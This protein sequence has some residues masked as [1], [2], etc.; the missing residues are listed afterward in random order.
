MES[1][2]LAGNQTISSKFLL[3]LDMIPFMQWWLVI[4]GLGLIFLPLSNLLFSNLSDKGY[5]F[6]KTIGIALSGYTMWFLSNIKLMKFRTISCILVVGIW[7]VFNLLI[8]IYKKY[9]TNDRQFLSCYIK[10]DNIRI[11]ITQEI[12][13][14]I[15]FLLFT[16][17][18]GFK[19]EAYGT[20]KFMDYGF[21]TTMMRSDYMPPQDFWFS[22]TKLNY[23]YVGQFLATFLTR[24]S[25]VEV[26]KGYNLMLMMIG[27]FAFML[28]FSLA[29]NLI[30]R[31][32]SV[33][34]KKPSILATLS[35]IFAGL[36]VCVAGNM[37][38]PIY[39]WI[40]PVLQRIKG[41]AK[42]PFSYW[43]PNATRYIGYNPETNDKTIHEFPAYSFILGDLH[44]HV[45]NILFVLTVLAVLLSW[46]YGQ[47]DKRKIYGFV[48]NKSKDK[49]NKNNENHE[50]GLIIK[51]KK[52]HEKNPIKN[53]NKTINID[54]YNDILKELLN[55]SIIII[56][57][58][59]GL[60][61]T[62]NFWDFP[63]YFVVS[64][65]IILF[66]N[67]ISYD[68]K[69]KSLW[70]T[71][72]QGIIIIVTSEII[73]LPFTLQFDQI[74]AMVYLSEN[75]TPFYQLMV[76]WGLPIF[77]VTVFLII[78]IFDYVDKRNTASRT[79]KSKKNNKNIST[80]FRV[81][82]L[83]RTYMESL[84]D[85]DLFVITIG[86]CAM[87][88]ILIPEIVY[89]KDI[90][91]GDYKRAN[92]MF[93]LT[94]QAFIIFGV[95]LGYIF[96]RL[97]KYGRK[98][99]QRITAT[100]SLIAFCLTLPYSVNAVKAW[101]GGGNAY[102]G[103]DAAAFMKEDFRDDYLATKWLNDNVSGTPV[104]LEANGLSYTDYQRVSVITGL[105]TVLGWYTHEQLWKSQPSKTND[106]VVSQLNTR[107]QD[108]EAIYTS[109]DKNLVKS[110]IDKYDVSYIYVGLLEEEKYENLNHDLIKSLGEVV[111][112]NPNSEE[113]EYKTYIVKIGI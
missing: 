67:L 103:I 61:H 1:I 37:H 19:P 75:H 105:P 6:S 30:I 100:I 31:F 63:I 66:S 3:G 21:M 14:F 69:I 54:N 8:V 20:E 38:Y 101:Y 77:T 73:A 113:Y 80:D 44:A 55:P 64:G 88:L 4:L 15:I 62:T 96:I 52:H 12:L 49:S 34:N 112:E 9:Y 84:S 7:I 10:K 68:F 90:Y 87:G 79:R 99:G 59:L 43:F 72:L 110:L 45:I 95:C 26:S 97:L 108:I 24:L 107:S 40:K 111:F 23:Y 16:Y 51:S 93:K 76:L 94:Y 25:F 32:G 92:T 85:T 74:S 35:G 47:F 48:N 28:P 56:G 13:F 57:F 104:V 33:R 42:A 82:K 11:I 36:G 78:T 60:F 2:L 29:Y 17:I 39:K 71:S 109:E 65:A 70:M 83:L 58:F 46:L 91:S 27:A 102:E 98:T 41:D 5:L 89:V 50:S 53:S 86:L 22:G 81:G 106:M 18:R